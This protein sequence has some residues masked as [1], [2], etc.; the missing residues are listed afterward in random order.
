M[1]KNR[2][3]E[4]FID[5]DKGYLLNYGHYFMDSSTTLTNNIFKK[6]PL[7][8]QLIYESIFFI[9]SYFQIKK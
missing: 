9:F 7:T 4:K 6:C 1:K 3:W 2:V 8:N 5:C